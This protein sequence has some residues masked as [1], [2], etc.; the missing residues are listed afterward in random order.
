MNRL[1]N[2]PV[3]AGT[4]AGL[5]VAALL[6]VFLLVKV[7]GE[8]VSWDQTEVYP[9]KTITV[10]GEGEVLAVPDIATFS[11]IVTEEADT[12]ESAQNLA[13]E[14]INKATDFLKS[15]GVEEKD[16]KTEYYNTYPKYDYSRVCTAFDCPSSTPKIIGYEVSQTIRVKVRQ[17]DEAGRF[18]TELGKI[19]IS[20]ISG[21]DFVIDDDGA[22]YD[23]ARGKAID[24][25]KTKAQELA[26]Q[27][28]VKLK[29]VISFGED[30]PN[31]YGYDRAYGLGGAEAMSAKA[32]PDLPAGENSYTSR[33][34]V[35]Y[36]IK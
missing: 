34:W 30:S 31:L 4:V 7:V 29:G 25:A 8:V 9:S 21:L 5:I 1:L 13:T 12:T 35:T 26:K 19:G 18:V 33:V 6:S 15:N 20:N 27:L 28:G 32:V 3:L 22:L 16:I 14:K 2:N 24:D 11:F 36:E 10:N 17:S 23:E